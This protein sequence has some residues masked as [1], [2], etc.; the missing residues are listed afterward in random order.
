MI[1]LPCKVWICRGTENTD[2]LDDITMGNPSECM[3]HTRYGKCRLDSQ[4]CDAR[5]AM[6]VWADEW[7]K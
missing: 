4:P 5:P 7:M 6:L 1:S 2:T 3:C